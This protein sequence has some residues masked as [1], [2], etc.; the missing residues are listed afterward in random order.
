MNVS[1]EYLF[2][3]GA[4]AVTNKVVLIQM[5]NEAYDEFHQV[6]GQP[7][8][9]A[10][11]AKLLSQLAGAGCPLVVFDVFF[12]MQRKAE[13]DATLAAAM[14]RHGRAAAYSLNRSSAAESREADHPGSGSCFRVLPLELAFQCAPA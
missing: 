8:D 3:F 2:R 14:R 13:T 5:D 4:R 9:L 6:R 7:W 11:H 12:G 1:Y 10:A